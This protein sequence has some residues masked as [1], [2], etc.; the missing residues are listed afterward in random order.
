M[1]EQENDS[2]G[3]IGAVSSTDF[4]TVHESTVP[5]A[6]SRP[7]ATARG[8]ITAT[9]PTTP[10]SPA[11]QPTDKEILAAVSQ[12]NDNLASYNRVLDFQ[13]DAGTGLSIATIRNAQTGAVLQQMPSPDMVKLAQMLADWSPGGTLQVDLL[14]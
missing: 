1:S 4:S 2:P 5:V 7:T 14:A 3:L 11:K 13:V 10:N 9:S 8:T 12:A 6:R